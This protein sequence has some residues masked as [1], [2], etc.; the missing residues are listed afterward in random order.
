MSP[1]LYVTTSVLIR[2]GG[3][4]GH[5]LHKRDVDCSNVKTLTTV[6]LIC[7]S[8]WYLEGTIAHCPNGTVC[9][10]AV[11]TGIKSSIQSNLCLWVRLLVIIL[12]DRH[13]C[14]F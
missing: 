7:Q 5:P 6:K 3:A 8:L 13:S 9:N 12:N 11:L 14:N 4:L 1:L 2:V 10:Q